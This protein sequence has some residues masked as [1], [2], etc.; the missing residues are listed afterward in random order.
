M[1][2]ISPAIMERGTM[3]SVVDGSAA[4][5]R[6]EGGPQARGERDAQDDRR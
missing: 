6:V 1:P 5:D 4:A 2:T 3:W